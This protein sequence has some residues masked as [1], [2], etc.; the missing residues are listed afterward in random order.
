M[1]AVTLVLPPEA[2]TDIHPSNSSG[3]TAGLIAGATAGVTTVELIEYDRTTDSYTIAQFKN[4]RLISF[5][6]DCFL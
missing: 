6:L 3:V 5:H 4:T 2:M 1:E